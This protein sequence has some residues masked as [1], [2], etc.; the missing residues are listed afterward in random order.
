MKKREPNF[1][2][3]RKILRHEKP[4]RPT[5]FEFA[6]AGEYQKRNA[7]PGL[8]EDWT[9]YGFSPYIISSQKN[10]GYDFICGNGSD[11]RFPTPKHDKGASV[12][13]A[14]G[15]VVKDRAALHGLD[16]KS[17]DEF[18]YSRLDRAEIPEGM[19]VI[20]R[21]PGGVLEVLTELF[22]FEE[23]CYQ[24]ADEP[25]LVEETLEMTGT[26]M[27]RYFEICASHPKVDVLLHSDD[28]GFKSSTILSP[29]QLREYIIPWHKKVVDVCH[30]HGKPVILHSCGKL[31][32]VMEDIIALGYD[33]KHSFEDAGT[34]VEEALARWGAKIPILGG[35]DMDFLCRKTPAEIKARA[36]KLLEMTAA[37]GGYALG[38]GNSIPGYMPYENYIA[39]NEVALEG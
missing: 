12:G 13:L 23:L 1:E 15:G 18:D 4:N 38:S 2:N 36:R 6:I 34:P 5:I 16:W 14:H 32:A 22:G 24:L 11:F 27:V 21:S 10:L 20:V 9:D 33:A 28:W 31:D 17:P 29:A 8:K 30:K 37:T 35:I 7:D 26:R 19:G 25:E 39:M 3:I